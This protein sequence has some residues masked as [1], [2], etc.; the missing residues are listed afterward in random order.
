MRATSGLTLENCPRFNTTG[1]RDATASNM[2]VVPAFEL[3]F[4]HRY[5]DRSSINERASR[6]ASA[7]VAAA[8]IV[9]PPLL[10]GSATSQNQHWWWSS[11]T[12]KPI[13]K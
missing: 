4:R 7:S 5:T 13:S 3:S 11:H 9:P 10:C 6:I 1:V 12:L 2:V 8:P